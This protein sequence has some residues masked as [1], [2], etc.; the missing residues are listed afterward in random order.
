M[1]NTS[2][3]VEHVVV[4]ISDAEAWADEK[5]CNS[6]DRVHRAQFGCRQFRIIPLKHFGACAVSCTDPKLVVE[7]QHGVDIQG[8]RSTKIVFD[9]QAWSQQKTGLEFKEGSCNKVSMDIAVDT[10][11]RIL[12]ELKIFAA[13]RSGKQILHG[14]PGIPTR[15]AI[16]HPQADIRAP[17][18]DLSYWQNRV[19]VIDRVQFIAIKC[20]LRDPTCQSKA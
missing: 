16:V 20:I 6:A 14:Y 10:F 17:R 5:L 2:K 4:G 18:A 11:E 15:V 12:V 8:C 3:A 13:V 19:I 9:Q 1:L 7:D